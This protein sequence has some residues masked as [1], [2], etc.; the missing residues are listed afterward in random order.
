MANN[1]ALETTKYTLF[2][3]VQGIYAHMTF[4]NE[5]TEGQNCQHWDTDQVEPTMEQVNDHF[6]IE[7][8]GS[9]AMQKEEANQTHTPAIY[10]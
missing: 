2:C 6:H 8:Q 10:I 1:E 4:L 7:L 9:K 3:A 5:L